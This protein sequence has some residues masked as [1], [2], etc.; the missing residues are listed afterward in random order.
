[1]TVASATAR[2][3][4]TGDAVT[5]SFATGP[6]VFFAD[7]DLT[8]YVVV[9]ATGVSE[10]LVLDTDYT[11]SGGDGSTGTVDLSG[12]SSPY[13]APAATQTVVIVRGVAITQSSDL[14]N[15]DTSDA[16]VVEDALDRLTMITQQIDT[17]VDRAFI[18]A[19]SDVSGVS[20]AMPTPAA[21][22]LLGFNAAGNAL[23]TYPVASIVGTIV[24]T[25]YMETLLN[26]ATATEA[27]ATLEV[28]GVIAA[29]RNLAVSRPS[30]ATVT[31]TADELLLKNSGGD[32]LLASTVSVTPNITASGANGLD[33]GAEGSSRF[34]FVWVIAKAD[35]TVAGLLSESATAPTMPATYTFKALVSAVYNSVGSAFTDYIQRGNRCYY[36]EARNVLSVGV[37]TVATAIPLTA[38]VP[39]IAE[40]FLVRLYGAHSGDTDAAGSVQ[41]RFIAGVTY[42]TA[43]WEGGAAQTGHSTQ[44]VEIPNVSRNL[45]YACVGT[46]ATATVDVLGFTLPV[47]M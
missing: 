33:T 28:K 11:V 29:C 36:A 30:V 8:V 31:V 46:N 5:T 23:T 41:L 3:S 21:S 47:G 1:M 42:Y 13:G 27:R 16:E 43:E 34:Y 40:A 10:T 17:R 18:L 15:S 26:D 38:A 39:A 9:T 2:K 4:F 6:M 44:L 12:G 19:D 22:E 25:A 35:G 45:E 24:P 7:A 20:L 14:I 32:Y 37:E